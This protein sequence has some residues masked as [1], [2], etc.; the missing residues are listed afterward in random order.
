MLNLA[1]LPVQLTK[2]IILEN[3]P[4]I[5]TR[6]IIENDTYSI[7]KADNVNK[8]IQGVGGFSEDGQLVGVFVDNHKL[9]FLFKKKVYQTT[10]SDLKCTNT[11][12]AK[13]QR[14]FCIIIGNE[15]VCEIVYK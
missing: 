4:K 3:Y 13:S 8:P 1:E 11:Y 12:T 2:M 6:I 14:C 15:K 5:N 10:P 9:C 7:Q